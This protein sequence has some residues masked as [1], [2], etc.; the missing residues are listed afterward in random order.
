MFSNLKNKLTGDKKILI[1]FSVLLIFNIA[2]FIN[3][4]AYMITVK[5]VNISVLHDIVT[6]I[7]AIII[8]GFI[9]TRLTKL[10]ELTDGSVYEIAY[11]IIMGLLSLT[12]SYFNKSTN[13]ESILA[14]FLEM[15]RMLS[16]VLIL[17]Y[18]ATKTKSFKAIV[19]GDQSNKTIFWQIVI[20][21]I[22]G[23]LA[24]YFT[25]DVNGIPAN[26]RGLIV[27]IS[28][29]LGGPYVGI[30]VGI[31]SGVW[32]YSMGGPTAL[33]CGV[34]TIMAGIVGSIVYKWNNGKFLRSYKAALLML[35]YS[36]FDMFL[37]TILTPKPDGVLIANALYAPMTFGSVLGILLFTLFLGEKKEEAEISDGLKQKVND[38]TDRI[39]YNRDIISANSDKISANSDIIDKNSEK[40]KEMS[41]ELN[42]YKDKVD[43]LERE[44]R[45]IKNKL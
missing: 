9:S 2:L 23:I 18:I 5:H 41:Q 20:C 10:K 11:L 29:M 36:G 26:A 24:S 31:I 27:M 12:I 8:L 22:L 40:I 28:S 39:S 16:V 25:M 15:F 37:I 6:I 33:A 34:A 14:P 32:R 19:R 38:N 35:L 21:S 7:S 1:L 3:I 13:S 30:P 44:L 45:D 43:K 42:E 17:T 4:F